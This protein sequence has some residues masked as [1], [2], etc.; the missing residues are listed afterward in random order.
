MTDGVVWADDVHVGRHKNE[1][2]KEGEA[3]PKERNERKKQMMKKKT[4]KTG[5]QSRLI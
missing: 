5:G 1:K 4:E 2:A 3:K